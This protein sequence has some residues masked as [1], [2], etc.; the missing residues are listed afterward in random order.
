MNH[1]DLRQRLRTLGLKVTPQRVV[2]WEAI[3]ALGNHPTVEQIV[4]FLKENHPNIAPGTVYYTLQTYVE[5]GL[6]K[7]VKTEKDIMRYDAI[8]TRHHHLYCADSDKIEDYFDEDLDIILENYFRKKRI[9]GFTVQ[10]IKLQ[11][12][13]NFNT[14]QNKRKK[15]NIGKTSRKNI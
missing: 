12:V 2:I 8:T 4:A 3:N 1:T 10:D 6:V 5:T 14:R 7:K 15:N 9:P 11:I 13:G